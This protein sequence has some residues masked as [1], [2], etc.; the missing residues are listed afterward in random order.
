MATI[1][2]KPGWDQGTVRLRSAIVIRLTDREA[3][4]LKQAAEEH[5]TSVSALMRGLASSFV[6]QYPSTEAPKPTRARTQQ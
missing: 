4:E 2:L 3:A 6:A 1:E 5:G